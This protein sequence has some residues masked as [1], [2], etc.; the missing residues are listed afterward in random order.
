[1]IIDH[2]IQ[3]IGLL[4]NFRKYL[5]IAQL[6]PGKFYLHFYLLTSM[7][8]EIYSNFISENNASK[9]LRILNKFCQYTDLGL[10]SILLSL[11]HYNWILNCVTQ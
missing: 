8:W 10:K 4:F 5:H 11:N 3:L 6:F 1:M 2:H 9:E 7:L